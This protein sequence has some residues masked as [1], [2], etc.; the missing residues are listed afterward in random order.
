MTRN[1]KQTK[2]RTESCL[3]KKQ[4]R[5]FKNLTFRH[6]SNIP[7]TGSWIATCLESSAKGWW[8]GWWDCFFGFALSQNGL[9][10]SSLEVYQF[11]PE[12]VYHPKRKVSSLPTIIFQGRAVKF[13]CVCVCLVWVGNPK[14]C[15]DHHETELRCLGWDHIWYFARL[16]TH[17]CHKPFEV[18]KVSRTICRGFYE[19]LRMY[20]GGGFKY[21]LCSSLFGEILQFD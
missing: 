18:G 14:D 16:Q 15:K 5:G 19:I 12:N 11:A 10:G 17:K 21:F 2:K 4:S 7:T 3:W 1:E 6:P 20:Q 13:W 8:A 9:V